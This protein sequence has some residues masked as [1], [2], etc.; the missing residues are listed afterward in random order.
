MSDFFN[1]SNLKN[2]YETGKPVVIKSAV[3]KNSDP[4][5][6]AR[7]TFLKALGEQI[8]FHAAVTK[9]ETFL[10]NRYVPKKGIIA[11]EIKP[12]WDGAS[13]P[14]LVFL[15]FGPGRINKDQPFVAQSL[16]MVG[17]ILADIKVEAEA[18]I[19]DDGLYELSI[20]ISE[21]RKIAKVD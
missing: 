17:E 6:A 11:K 1:R 15:K 5:L 9:G 18:G 16:A 19:Y 20:K 4:K 14:Y 7:E 8:A 3:K 12:W 10:V 21:G 13:A 2:K